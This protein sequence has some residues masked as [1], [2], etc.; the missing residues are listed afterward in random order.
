MAVLYF[1]AALLTA[2][3]ILVELGGPGL[4]PAIGFWIYP[5]IQPLARTL[6]GVWL[7]RHR[8]EN[9]GPVLQSGT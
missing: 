1:A 9:A 6:I 4:P 8:D 3:I 7:W 5:L 2:L